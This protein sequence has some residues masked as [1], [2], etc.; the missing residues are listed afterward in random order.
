MTI[1]AST[2]SADR[3]TADPTR[4]NARAGGIFYLLTFA[5]SIPALLLLS[6]VLNDAGYITSAGQDTRV[7]WGC[8]L[9]FVNAVTCIGTAVAVYP[10]VKRRNESLALGFVTS[11]MLE[12]A[13]VMIGVVSLLA[14]VT[15]RQDQAGDVATGQALVAVRDW[16]FLFG[17]GFMAT[18][19]AILFGT[20]L[21]RSRLVPRIIPTMGLIGAPL[22]F[23]A[24]LLTVFG[25]NTQTSGWSLL[26]T[27][28]VAAWELSVGIYMTTKGFRRV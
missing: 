18:V 10:V 11:R 16:T 13:I 1:T 19:N 21:Y 7:L 20:L 15:L 27:L 8:F 14:L 2:A 17:P 9:D 25:H 28:P 22:L 26:A 4:N 5:A 6:P 3:R 23:T 24:N 12:A